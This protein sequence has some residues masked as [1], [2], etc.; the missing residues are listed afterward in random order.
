[1]KR[2]ADLT[3]W[4]LWLALIAFSV[5]AVSERLAVAALRT[6]PL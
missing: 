1:M 6:F 3:E 2:H 5:L 4:M